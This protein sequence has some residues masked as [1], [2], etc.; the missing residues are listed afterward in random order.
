MNIVPM[1]WLVDRLGIHKSIV[2]LEI[3]VIQRFMSSSHM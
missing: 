1:V 2:F 3:K